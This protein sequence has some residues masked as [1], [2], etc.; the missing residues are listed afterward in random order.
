MLRYI[1][2]FTLSNVIINI[3]IGFM[4]VCSSLVNLV[5]YPTSSVPP[6]CASVD[7][8]LCFG[9]IIFNYRSVLPTEVVQ[10][11][12]LPKSRDV[13]EWEQTFNFENR[14]RRA[15]FWKVG[16]IKTSVSKDALAQT[17]RRQM[18]ITHCKMGNSFFLWMAKSHS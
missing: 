2:L 14:R 11:L 18:V 5:Y 1:G 17:A 9:I 3:Q 16:G 15:L 12:P 10:C 4:I 13:A 7:R 8:N 6:F